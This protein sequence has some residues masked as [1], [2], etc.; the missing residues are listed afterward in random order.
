M[1]TIDQ[2]T[3]F[4]FYT[5]SSKY[6]WTYETFPLGWKWIGSGSCSPVGCKTTTQYTKEEQ[7]DG[8]KETKK[9]MIEFLK[10]TFDKLKKEQKITS[11]KIENIYKTIYR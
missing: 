8:P 5:L 6:Y 4:V 9:E 11:F 7:F 3:L 2:K 1:T 10:N